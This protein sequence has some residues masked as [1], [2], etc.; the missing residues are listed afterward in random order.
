MSDFWVL[1]YILATF[2]ADEKAIMNVSTLL[3]Y[4]VG[5]WKT[6]VALRILETCIGQLSDNIV[7]AFQSVVEIELEVHSVNITLMQ[8]VWTPEEPD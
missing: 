6:Q 1:D 2:W 4:S 7:F 8:F 3:V 5:S